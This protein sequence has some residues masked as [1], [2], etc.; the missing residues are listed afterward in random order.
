MQQVL[1]E[2]PLAALEGA[3][4]TQVFDV[5]DEVQ[6]EEIL[7]LSVKGFVVVQETRLKEG[8]SVEDLEKLAQVTMC[9][10]LAKQGDTYTLVVGYKSK[11]PLPDL[12]TGF[13][14]LL[15]M[16]VA[17]FPNKC[18]VKFL[19]TREGLKKLLFQFSNSKVKFKIL[20]ISDKDAEKSGQD[21]KLTQKQEA[22][23]RY[24]L[25][26]GYF[27]I[28]R[29]ISTQDIAREFSITPAAILEHVRKGQKK[30]FENLY[31]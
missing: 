18:Q 6:I 23:L 3:G 25:D 26:N 5:A 24:A 4:L 12:L 14:V 31:L 15:K 29:A 10:V 11:K 21:P 9:R 2:F 7:K 27:E 13:E 16:P 19:G 1:I 17:F 22:V 30:I 28:P 8:K 20:S